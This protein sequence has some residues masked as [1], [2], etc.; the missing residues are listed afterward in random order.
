M[1]VEPPTARSLTGDVGPDYPSMACPARISRCRPGPPGRRSAIEAEL[2]ALLLAVAG[3]RGRDAGKGREALGGQAL[4]EGV[5][6]GVVALDPRGSCRCAPASRPRRRRPTRRGSADPGRARP[7]GRTGRRSAALRPAPRPRPAPGDWWERARD[8]RA[9][10]RD[11]LTQHLVEVAQHLVQLLAPELAGRARASATWPTSS[12]NTSSRSS[13]R[14]E[15]C[16]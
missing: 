4:V 9:R 2:K 7:H 3:H 14:P 16:A 15:T 11:G 13:S 6:I 8:R 1:C 12:S 10:R 5:D